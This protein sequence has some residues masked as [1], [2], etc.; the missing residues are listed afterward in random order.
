MIDWPPIP[1]VTEVSPPLYD[2]GL[3]CGCGHE[4]KVDQTYKRVWPS[5]L[6]ACITSMMLLTTLLPHCIPVVIQKGFE[7]PP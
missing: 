6:V 2:M 5:R 4:I 3:E 7:V 1:S